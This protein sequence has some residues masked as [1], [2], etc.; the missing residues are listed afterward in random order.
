MLVDLLGRQ[1]HEFPN[2]RGTSKVT[3]LVI[4]FA[5]WIVALPLIAAVAYY[6]MVFKQVKRSTVQRAGAAG[7]AGDAASRQQAPDAPAV[8]SVPAAWHPDPIGRHELRYWDG[9]RW[10]QHVSDAGVQSTDPLQTP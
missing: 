7:A 3:W 9:S 6:F 5:S 1:E 4:M 2:S 8:A 10:S